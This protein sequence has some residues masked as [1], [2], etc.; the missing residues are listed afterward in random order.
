MR[1]TSRLIEQWAKGATYPVLFV[2]FF[3]SVQSEFGDFGK[4]TFAKF[5]FMKSF[6]VIDVWAEA[7]IQL[8]FD[9]SK[10]EIFE[11]EINFKRQFLI[12]SC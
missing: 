4:R 12:G 9:S 2:F 5:F 6:S 11:P 10:K 7:L 3:Y 1:R 8:F